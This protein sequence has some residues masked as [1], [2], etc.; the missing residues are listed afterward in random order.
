VF[1]GVGFGNVLINT[2]EVIEVISSGEACLAELSA[3]L[4]MRHVLRSNLK[5]CADTRLTRSSRI[6]AGLLL[7]GTSF[8][9]EA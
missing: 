7:W 5:F 3:A 9:R 2:V 4:T 1:L 8:L 6:A